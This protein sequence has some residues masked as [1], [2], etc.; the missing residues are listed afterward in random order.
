[1]D[2]SHQTHDNYKGQ[3][4]SLFMFGKSATTSSSTK[5]KIPSKSSSESE[6]IAL[7]NKSSDILWTCHFLEA[8][9]YNISTNVMFQDNISTLFLAKNGYF[10]SLNCT[11]IFLHLPL[12]QS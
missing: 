11:K 4:G 10:S 9:G 5:Q 12:S 2:G 7:H 3:V 6:I 1:V 8:Q